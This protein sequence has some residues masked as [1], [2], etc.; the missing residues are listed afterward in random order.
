M[1]N[2]EYIN[3]I[4]LLIICSITSFKRRETK[5]M[6][7]AIIHKDTTSFLKAVCCVSIILHHFALRNQEGY[8]AWIFQTGGG[9]FAVPMF[10]LLSS[11]GICKS[12]LSKPTTKRGF[13]KHR[14]SKLLIPFVVVNIL[15]IL[16]YYLCGANCSLDKLSN[17]RVN[18]AFVLI[19]SREFG[20]MD[21]ILSVVG[22]KSIDAAMWF[23]HVIIYAYA[24]FLVSKCI[25][26]IQKKT[27]KFTMLFVSL[28]YLL[29]I[30][31]YII[32]APIHFYR[33]LW[34]LSL[35]AILFLIENKVKNTSLRIIYGFFVFTVLLTPI[36]AIERDVWIVMFACLIPLSLLLLKNI[37]KY[38]ELKQSSAIS[39]LAGMSY[40]MYLIHVKLLT[41]EWWFVGYQSAFLVVLLS[42]MFAMIYEQYPFK[43]LII[44]RNN[45]ES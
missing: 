18:E 13:L 11:Y 42:L 34:A 2:M 29:S 12:E 7:D 20:I 4:L 1:N 23:V 21:Y 6:C 31:L 19:G 15:T 37:V 33:S 40:V 3:A 28:I 30:I 10:F 26:D 22:I 35:G 9:Y 17:T 38:I 27:L 43:Y 16:M 14:F 24:S 36:A 25:F 32:D 41:L 39:L 5:L 8:F 44:N 45:H